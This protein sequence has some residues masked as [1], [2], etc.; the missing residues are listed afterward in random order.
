VPRR[1]RKEEIIRAIRDYLNTDVNSLEPITDERLM[2]AANC[3]RATFYKYVTKGSTIEVEIN[4]ARI[5]QEKDA[6]AARS[7]KD[8]IGNDS[9]LRKR[10]VE[11]EAGARELL[12][13]IARFTSNLIY[14]GVQTEVLQAA[15]QEAMAHPNRSLSYA[16]R[17]RRRK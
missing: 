17:G 4:V 5:R 7:G 13:Y 15:A 6:E 12:A 8:A 16:G 2:K 14:H 1:P 9:E 10:L 11:A 3:A